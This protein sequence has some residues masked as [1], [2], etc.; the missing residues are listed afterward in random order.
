[1]IFDLR[2]AIKTETEEAMPEETESTPAPLTPSKVAR[3][4]LQMRVP[5]GRIQL[6][7]QS[8][9]KPTYDALRR[10]LTFM[11]ANLT[12]VEVPASI[13]EDGIKLKEWIE[14]YQS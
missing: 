3:D 8:M 4:V 6:P 2:I 7:K 9:D 13:D 1:L 11:C 12:N 10:V 14:N 5:Y